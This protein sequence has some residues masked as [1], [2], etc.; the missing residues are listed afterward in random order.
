MVCNRLQGVLVYIV[1]KLFKK[2]RK[3]NTIIKKYQFNVPNLFSVTV[4]PI[5]LV[6]DDNFPYFIPTSVI[7]GDLIA[8]GEITL[9]KELIPWLYNISVA[10]SNVKDHN[11]PL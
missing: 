2:A 6:A 11:I 10:N 8:V 9:G 3:I 7:E 1:D 5:F 4:I